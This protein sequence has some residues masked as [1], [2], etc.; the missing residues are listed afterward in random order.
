MRGISSMFGAKRSDQSL[1]TSS[2][3]TT[4]LHPSSVSASTKGPSR[5]FGSLSR[6]SV[7][8]ARLTPFACAK[9][10][11]QS[12]SSSS[13]GSNSLRTPGDDEGLVRNNSKVAWMPWLVRKRSDVKKPIVHREPWELPRSRPPL[14]LRSPPS[15]DAPADETEDE[16][17]SESENE[18]EVTSGSVDLAALSI[19]PSTLAK[20]RNNIRAM[21]DNSL[22]P[23]FSPPPVLHVPGQPIF[24]RSCNVR[25]LLYKQETMETRIHKIRIL[26]RFDH[27]QVTHAEELSIIS[28]GLRPTA[29]TKRLS[30]QLDDEALSGTFQLRTYSQGLQKWALRPCFE[31]RVAVWTVEEGTGNVL[32]TRVAGTNFGVAALEISE[33]LDVLAGAIPEESDLE[34]PLTQS[35]SSLHVP[36]CK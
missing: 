32:C 31:D 8:N 9:D 11:T 14:V 34:A 28:F 4:D 26:Q 25:R 33:A 18:S 15:R 3:S 20:S 6:K 36:V 12:S 27:Q 2:P 16:S 19:T 30:L 7:V 21:I 23:P 13:S 5:L 1:L 10:Q 24:P 22:Q 29:T 17:S 35:N